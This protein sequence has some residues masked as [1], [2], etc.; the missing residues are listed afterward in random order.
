MLAF[1][2]VSEV[3]RAIDIVFLAHLTCRLADRAGSKEDG[4]P[5][6][7]HASIVSSTSRV[8]YRRMLEIVWR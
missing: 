4:W 3:D 1:G 2:E 6:P 5:T 8:L 7:M